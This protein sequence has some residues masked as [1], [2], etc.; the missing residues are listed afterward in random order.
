MKQVSINAA[1]YVSPRIHLL[2]LGDSAPLCEST[3]NVVELPELPET[4]YGEF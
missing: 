3:G 4:D 2:L 1:E